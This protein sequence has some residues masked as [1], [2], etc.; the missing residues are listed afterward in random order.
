M[1]LSQ[2]SKCGHRIESA[3]RELS[4][5]LW[6]SFHV[7][8]GFHL[9]CGLAIVGQAWHADVDGSRLWKEILLK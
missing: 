9:C 6:D 2:Q 4:V 1:I 5:S 8:P 7:L 3:C